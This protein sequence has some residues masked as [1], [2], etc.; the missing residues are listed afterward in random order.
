MVNPSGWKCWNNNDDE[1]Q[2][3]HKQVQDIRSLVGF[4]NQHV[5]ELVSF[6][7]AAV[8]RKHLQWSSLH[9]MYGTKGNT[10]ETS[11]KSK[12]LAFK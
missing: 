4:N 10:F 6:K 1:L 7:T 9:N 12:Y 3:E 8:L 2:L 5:S 11:K